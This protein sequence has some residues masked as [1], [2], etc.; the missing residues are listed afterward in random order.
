MIPM[1]RPV[2]DDRD[3]KAVER[4]LRS[5][6]W[7]SGPEVR[8]FE[9]EFAQ[10]LQV[11]HAIAVTNGTVALHAAL[12]GVDIQPG[13]RILTTPF[14]FIATTNSILYCQARP[15][16]VDVDPE[17]F[18]IDLDQVEVALRTNTYKAVLVVHLFGQM[19][20][21]QRL[22]QLCDNAGVALIEDCAQS[23][24]A[25][26][27]G[28][29][30]GV[31]G[32]V[33]TYSFYA[34][35]NLATGEGGMVTTQDDQRATRIRQLINHGRT[36]GYEHGMV[37]F[38]YRM[39]SIIA[40]LG[41]TQMLRVQEGNQRRQ[42]I[43]ARYAQEIHHPEL[44]HP[45]I[46]PQAGHVFHQYTLRC[47]RRSALQEHLQQRGISSAIVYPLL[48]YQQQSYL[49]L[50]LPSYHLPHAER[51]VNE[52]LSIPIFPA[53]SEQ[54]VDTIIEACNTFPTA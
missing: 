53:L 6:Y 30:G 43:A 46:D 19:C 31:L 44:Q 20:P 36:G 26:Y 39:T 2:V 23:H 3:L 25:T 12:L 41:R 9:E 48:S 11:K 47:T 24:G 28:V 4:I 15:D 49:A 16:F 8:A 45:T 17:T 35:K 40:A 32:D 54:E 10:W 29:Q 27:A 51:L 22:R 18:L 37:G 5:G 13:D 52:V 50:G 34:T 7:A 14:T 42:A 38:N 33:G 1:A 21:I